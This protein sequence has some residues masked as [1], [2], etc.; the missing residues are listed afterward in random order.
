MVYHTADPAAVR[1]SDLRPGSIFCDH[2]TVFDRQRC[3]AGINTDNRCTA[4]RNRV[5][6]QIKRQLLTGA[7]C[8][9]ALVIIEQYGSLV[10]IVFCRCY[11]ASI[12]ILSAVFRRRQESSRLYIGS[13]RVT[14]FN[15]CACSKFNISIT[16]RFQFYIVSQ[17]QGKQILAVS[18]MHTKRSCSRYL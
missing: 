8:N 9:A 11:K 3:I 7:Q 4:A 16:C 14:V 6:V 15:T 18:G 5:T 10:H 13:C 12:D 1:Q 2:C 17:R